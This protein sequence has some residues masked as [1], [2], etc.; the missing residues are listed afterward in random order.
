MPFK[1]M[2]DELPQSFGANIAKNACKLRKFAQTVKDM[3]IVAIG[4]NYTEH[5]KELHNPVPEKPIIFLK[6]DT[7]LLK[8]NRDFYYP[9]FSENIHHEVEIVLRICK[10]GRHIGAKFAQDRKSDV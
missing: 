9:E 4:R 1:S 3:K 8:D 6:P 5:A 7:A 2:H 10:E